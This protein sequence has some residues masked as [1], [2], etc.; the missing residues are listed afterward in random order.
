VPQVW[1]FI[2]NPDDRKAVELVVSQQVFSR[3]HVVAPET[4]A[5]HVKLLRTA[6]DAIMTDKQFLTD[7]AKSRLDISPSSGAKLQ[8]LVASV[9]ATPAPI[10][11]RAR[12][13]IAP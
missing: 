13:I 4:P 12:R 2:K 11:E 9:Y 7:A 6:Y 10:V 8:K 5:E 1:S 3:P